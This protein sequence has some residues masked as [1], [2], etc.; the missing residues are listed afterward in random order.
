VS[1]MRTIGLLG[2]MSWE[3]S[4]S[5]YAEVNRLVAQRLGGLHSARLVLM[6]VDFAQ[7]EA[8]QRAEDW[9]A[10][11][12]IL[13]DAASNLEAAGADLLVL[14]T[15]TMHQ[16]ADAITAATRVP[17]LHIAD[18]T[19]ARIV[20]DGHHRVG[21]LGTRFTMERGFYRDR[22]TD[23]FDLE[24][25]V[26]GPDDR[27]EV[28]RIIFDELVL[29]R[30]DPDSRGRYL[31]VI[32]RLVADGAQAIILGC[33]EIGLLVDASHTDVP[34]YDTTQLHALAAV[35]AALRDG[36]TQSPDTL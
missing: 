35:D 17:F 1:R 25:V 11:G 2:G 9:D 15:N 27:A 21:L 28:D 34:L 6:S 24:V 12:S 22:L 18:P 32:D 36:A 10:A 14:C 8:L 31:D 3:S 16:V 29:G 7:I 26:P 33:T 30:I 4:A 13:A 23:R 5:Y 20:A 19:A